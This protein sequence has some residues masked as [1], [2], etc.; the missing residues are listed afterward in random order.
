[1]E[2]TLTGAVIPDLSFAS[3]SIGYAAAEL[4]QVWKT[5]NGG[6]T[7]SEILNLGGPYYFYGVSALTANDVVISGFYDSTDFEGLIRWSHDG[8]QTWSDDIIVTPTGSVQRVRF[9]NTDNGL[10]M[11]L[12]G[13]A[14]GNTAQFTTDGGATASD[15]TGPQWAT[16]PTAAGLACNSACSPICTPEPP[17]SIS[18]EARTEEPSGAAVRQSIPSLMVPCSF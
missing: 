4:G 6:K 8:G 2:A 14:S 16:I 11:D 13:G 17:A 7:W 15:W 3:P 1:L 9:P 10:I 18:A 5:T 12:V